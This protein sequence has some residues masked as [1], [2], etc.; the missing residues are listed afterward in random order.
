MSKTISEKSK[1]D[2]RKR[3]WTAIVYPESA[4]ENW[5]EILNEE[6]IEWVVSPLH[7]KDITGTG[8]AK[9]P[10]YHIALLFDG[11]KSFEQI[12]EITDKINAPIPKPIASVRALIR[13]FAHLDD[14]DKVQ[15]PISEIK[16]FGG[17]DL[18][19]LLKPTSSSRYEMIAEMGEYIQENEITEFIDFFIFCKKNHF[20][21]WFP[22][23]CDS[24]SFVIDKVIKSNRHRPSKADVTS[25]VNDVMKG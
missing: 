6:H 21:D 2:N 25:L 10:H 1:K 5:Q 17:V 16:A 22:L 9:K 18:A 20:E 11:N 13:Y 15:Y 14:A 12:K 24:S 19:E 3:N 4:P 7:D 23:L 8:E